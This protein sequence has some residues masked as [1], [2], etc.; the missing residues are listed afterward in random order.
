MDAAELDGRFRSHSPCIPPHLVSRM[1]DLGHAEE[2]AFQAGRGEWFCARELAR[3]LDGQGRRAEAW[4]VITP[5][6]ATGWWMAA[7][8]AAGLLEGWGRG[9][10]AI[11]LV[12]PYAESGDRPALAVFARLLARHGRSGEAFALLLPH[13][14][15]E[16]LATALVDVAGLAGQDEEAAALLAARIDSAH[17]STGQAGPRP[18]LAP[19]NAVSLLATVRERQGR[20]DEAIALLRPG[21]A[22]SPDH[23]HQQLA[24]L[25][26]RHGRTEELRRYAGELGSAAQRLA[27]LLEERGD[28]EGAIAV[29]RSPRGSQ[30]LRRYGAVQ[31]AALLERHDRRAEAIGVLRS[32]ADSPPA[33]AEDWLVRELCAL[34]AA[35]GRAED[36]LAYLDALKSLTGGEEWTF[37][38]MRLPLLT[39]CGRREEAIALVRAHPEAGTWYA[40]T[41][42]AQL[43]ADA[44]RTEEAA[45][46]LRAHLPGSAVDLAGHLITLGRVKEA[47]S[48]LQEH[49]S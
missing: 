1:F 38:E 27:E 45:A 9:D 13:A 16:F 8:A 11:A 30:A 26:A 7:E 6:V 4:E 10:E 3:R 35:H 24:D 29:Y 20:I 46:V 37:F 48:V 19:A 47:L 23:G 12:R 18:G 44:G 34:Y 14:G 22:D 25:L 21:P 39:T 42:L 28:V 5:Y 40:A 33:G 2:V 41:S 32:L 31:L 15:D 17:R 43:L 49:Q 36:G